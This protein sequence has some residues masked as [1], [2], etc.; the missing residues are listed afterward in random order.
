MAR[1]VNANIANGHTVSQHNYIGRTPLL[2]AYEM[3]RFNFCNQ[4]KG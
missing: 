4:T 1:L 2:S 3:G